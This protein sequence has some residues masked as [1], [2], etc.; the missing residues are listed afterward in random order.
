MLEQISIFLN[1]HPSEVVILSVRRDV[2]YLAGPGCLG[3]LESDFWVAACLKRWLGRQLEAS[4]TVGE[5][6]DRL[7]DQTEVR[8]E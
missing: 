5:L 3:I 2:A 1:A 4:V 7:V 8:I 6:V